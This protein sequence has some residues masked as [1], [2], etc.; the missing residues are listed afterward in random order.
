MRSQQ[1]YIPP[2]SIDLECAYYDMIHEQ[3]GLAI[4][5][6]HFKFDS[7]KYRNVQRNGTE[8]DCER[9]EKTFRELD[10][11]VNIYNDLKREEISRILQKGNICVTNV[12]RV[13]AQLLLGVCRFHYR[14]RYFYVVDASSPLKTVQKMVV[15]FVVVVL[16]TLHGV[17]F[18]LLLFFLNGK[19]F[20]VN[21]CCCITYMFRLKP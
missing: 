16:L 8:K 10:F 4:I 12:T 6:N 20:S 13:N 19:C 18:L 15:F 21:C 3:R 5:L 17:I 7:K 11:E 1:P 2:P 9:L 14:L